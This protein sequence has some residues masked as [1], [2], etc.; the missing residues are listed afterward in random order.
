MSNIKNQPK[1]AILYSGFMDEYIEC[2]LNL[3]EKHNVLVDVILC[4]KDKIFTQKI[5]KI[6]KITADLDFKNPL[7]IM[8]LDKKVKKITENENYDYIICDSFTLSNTAGI[9]HSPSITKRMQICP[10]IIYKTIHFLTHFNRIIFNKFFYRKCPKLFVVSS[11]LKDDYTQNINLPKEKIKVVFPGFQF[12][13]N[14]EIQHK[15]R[16]KN[17]FIVGMSAN[18]FSTKGGFILL[19]AIKILKKKYPQ[20]KA[21]IIYAKYANNLGINLCMKFWN[22]KNNVEFLDFQNDMNKFYNSLDCLVCP[23]LCEA[24]GRVVTEAMNYKVPVIV[25][26]TTGAKDIIE[27]QKNGLIF[28]RKKYSGK[29][30]AQKIEYIIQ[31]PDK[32]ES[33]ANVAYA[34]SQDITWEKFAKDIFYELYPKFNH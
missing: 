26:S 27:H 33:M 11:I 9:M 3:C 10:N 13:P 23:S 19:D 8:E 34:T 18:G 24:F 22:I 21:K 14:A 1:L 28:E 16:K 15:K 30:L 17:E 25:S 4:N 32:A 12:N 29:D 7:K 5:N 6:A 31:N 2:F 20:I